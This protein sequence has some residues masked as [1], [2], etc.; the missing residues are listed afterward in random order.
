LLTFRNLFLFALSCA[1]TVQGFGSYR[2][3]P[4][5][6]RILF[7]DHLMF[8]RSVLLSALKISSDG[9]IMLPIG[10]YHVHPTPLLLSIVCCAR[11]N[12]VGTE[13][14]FQSLSKV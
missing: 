3:A 2:K 9:S 12:K 5:V 14:S 6:Q 4:K 10:K 13:K 7:T 11:N 1:L 8:L